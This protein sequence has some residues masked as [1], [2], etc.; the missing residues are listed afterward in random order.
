MRAERGAGRAG[1]DSEF[2]PGRAA[3]APGAELSAASVYDLRAGFTPTRSAWPT[4]WRSLPSDSPAARRASERRPAQGV[5]RVERAVLPG[6]SGRPD[7]AQRLGTGLRLRRG[8]RAPEYEIDLGARGRPGPGA[9]E[10][11]GA[12]VTACGQ[13]HDGAEQLRQGG[14]GGYDMLTRRAGGVRQGRA[15]GPSCSSTPCGRGARSI[16]A[17]YAGCRLAHRARTG[18]PGSPRAVRRP[19]PAPCPTAARDTVAAPRPRHGRPARRVSA[20]CRR[21]CRRARQ[22]GPGTAAARSSGSMPATRCRGRPVVGRD[23]RACR[24]WS[25]S[26]GSA[27]GAVA[28]G[29]SRLRLGRRRAPAR[30]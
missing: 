28:L 17:R 29:R 12:P 13:L 20:G 3:A 16:P 4:S 27:T 24:R 2:H 11:A 25:C 19:E 26:A 1:T 21:A 15:P 5:P 6:G 9:F 14:G 30:A 22:P 23:P 18:R 10:S 7:R 8:R